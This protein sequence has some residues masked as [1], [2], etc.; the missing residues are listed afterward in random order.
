MMKHEISAALERNNIPYP[1][2]LPEKL[3][4]YLFLLSEWNEKM[5]LTAVQSETEIR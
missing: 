4:V 5:D 2:D 1:S 3:E